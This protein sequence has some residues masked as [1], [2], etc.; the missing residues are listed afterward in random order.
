MFRFLATWLPLVVFVACSGRS[1]CSGDEASSANSARTPD[2]TADP[3]LPGMG[4]GT[5]ALMQ[6]LNAALAAKGPD[7]EPRTHHFN[8]DGTPKYVNRLILET[9]PYL[10]QHAHNPVN[11]YPWGDEAFERAKREDKPVLLSVGYSTCHWC[12]VM[13]RESFEDEEIARVMNEH[14]INIKVDREERPDIDQIY[15]AALHA[16]GEQGGWPMTMFLTEDAEPFFGGTYFPARDGDRG[17]RKGFLTILQEMKAEYTTSRDAVVTRAQQLSQRIAAA[18]APSRPGDVPG[19]TLIDRAARTLAQSFDP[20]FGGFGRAPK[21]PRPVTLELLLR[22]HRRTGDAQALHMVV[23]TLE[24]MAAGGM[25]DQ[26][27]GGFHRYSTDARWLVPHFEK[28]LYDNA[29]LAPLYLSAYQLTERDD[30]ARVARET[31]R[32]VVREMTSPQGG[33]YSATDADSPT[34]E[35]HDEEGYFFTWTPA[36]IEAVFGAEDARIVSAYYGVAASGNFEGRSILHRPRSD[37]EVASELGITLGQ[38][39]STLE[40]A[41]SRL[42]RVRLRRPAPHRDD[43]VLTSWNGLMISAF[44]KAALIL[45]DETYAEQA[46]KAAAFVLR[47]L[48]RDDGR[49]LRSFKDGRARHNGYLDDYAFFIQGLL[50]LY[51]ATSSLRWLEEAV[52]LQRVLDQ[53]Y[54]DAG[55][56]GYFMTSDDHEDL[57]A[58]DKPTY[59]G[60]EPSGNSVALLNLMRLSEL[61]GEYRERAERGLAAF[62]QALSRSPTTSPKMLSALDFY[63]DTPLEVFVVTPA[64]GGD[65]APLLSRF[66]RAFL[67]NRVFTLTEE[68][69]PLSRRAR[70]IHVLEGKRALQGRSTAFVCERGRCELPTSDPDTFDRQLGKV[71]P[72]LDAG[73]V[74]PLSLPQ[75]GAEPEPWEYDPATNRHWHPG[76]MHWHQGRPPSSRQRR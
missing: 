37:A 40:S 49:L 31:L 55:A 12:H 30:F 25:Y 47:E 10:L 70:V 22:Y 68:G 48:K 20:V 5:P 4:D 35:G 28:M 61:T 76:H 62:S 53:H 54:W 73:A 33:F 24:K 26:V 16:T 51:E 7:H 56:G 36:E 50:D 2:S 57:L 58:R 23:H 52:A 67:P 14:F 17:A 75:P 60:A 72:L 9:S 21:F 32:Y 64:A 59:D 39:S 3:A 42:Y 6:R 45:A 66:R 18:A 15:M 19:P 65:P 27:G 1:G 44:A 69:E 29:Q 63:L 11:W 8:D 38:L 71:V 41:R 34:P 46:S 74:A 43:K 13:E